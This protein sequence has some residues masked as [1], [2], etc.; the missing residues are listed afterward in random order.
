MP[1]NCKSKMKS[2][3][4]EKYRR[5]SAVFA[6]FFR[7]HV[8]LVG[9]WFDFVLALFWIFL[10]YFFLLFPS[11]FFC[12]LFLSEIMFVPT[13][14]KPNQRFAGFLLSIDMRCG[15]GWGGVR[16]S[17]YVAGPCS[18]T[19]THTS[20]HVAGPFSCT[21]THTSCYVAGTF[22]CTSTHTS[23]YVAGTFSCTSTHT[24]CYATHGVG[25]C[26][27]WRISSEEENG[28]PKNCTKMARALMLKRPKT[29]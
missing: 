4:Q 28:S 26:T 14:W 20:C 22:S 21:S 11:F 27:S 1:K 6:T 8:C 9:P 12:N 15:A 13:G 18:C 5:E 24:S 29:M 25:L 2:Q 19:S 23:C 16:T 7:N 3:M 17:C 10:T